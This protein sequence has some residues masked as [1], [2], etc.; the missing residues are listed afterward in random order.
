VKAL[1]A[2]VLA[3]WKP[4]AAATI[5]GTA[6][7]RAQHPQ[8][9]IPSIL[10]AP[11]QHRHV[12]GL[13][14]SSGVTIHKIVI[15]AIARATPKCPEGLKMDDLSTLLKS[16]VPGVFGVRVHQ[17]TFSVPVTGLASRMQYPC[18]Q[19]EISMAEGDAD[20]KLL[21]LHTSSH[22]SRPSSTHLCGAKTAT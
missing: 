6:V 7:L 10:A 12:T 13:S 2:K 22:L 14:S 20:L 8:P 5:A 3:S 18:W 4:Q 19:V 11:L 21:Q 17:N 15:K 16:A 9:N 1:K